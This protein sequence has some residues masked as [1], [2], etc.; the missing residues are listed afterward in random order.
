[1]SEIQRTSPNSAR[2]TAAY[3]HEPGEVLNATERAISGLSRWALEGRDE[4]GLHAVRATSMLS[5]KDD[6]NATVE[7]GD[8]PGWTRL[9]LT[10][11]SR[12]GKSDFGQNPRNL[13]ELLDALDRELSAQG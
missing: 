7:P 9:K 1:M 10:S 3:E 6:V 5:F 13:R 8:T 12:S 11:S 4:A 2:T